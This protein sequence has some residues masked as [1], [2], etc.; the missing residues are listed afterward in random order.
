MIKIKI[1]VI[2]FIDASEEAIAIQA[3]MEEVSNHGLY[4]IELEKDSLRVIQLMKG[5]NS[6]L[7]E[8][9]LLVFKAKR[10]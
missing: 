2:K 4:F 8:L 5:S 3:A 9:D 1:R 7:N 10:A 6:A